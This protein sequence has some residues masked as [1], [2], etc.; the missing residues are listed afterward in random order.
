MRR[1]H[2]Y[3]VL[4]YVSDYRD[5]NLPAKETPAF[6]TL[7]VSVS[8]N[9]ENFSVIH[10]VLNVVCIL[11]NEKCDSSPENQVQR[12]K[13][14]QIN[15]FG[16]NFSSGILPMPYNVKYQSVDKPHCE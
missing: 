14:N 4:E 10:N 3:S 2:H 8:N 1:I 5:K 9:A 13:M 7:S 12:L 11:H 15:S 6:A 16:A